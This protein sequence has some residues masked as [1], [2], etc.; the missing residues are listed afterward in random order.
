MKAA[1]DFQEETPRPVDIIL[2]AIG[3]TGSGK[4]LTLM[5]CI[6]DPSAYILIPMQFTVTGFQGLGQ[7]W[8]CS[9]LV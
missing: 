9:P 4:G 3:G 8:R 5:V 6:I 2:V 7:H 1:E